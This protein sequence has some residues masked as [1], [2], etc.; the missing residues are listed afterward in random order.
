MRYL[1]STPAQK[2]ERTLWLKMKHYGRTEF[3]LAVEVDKMG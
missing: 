2:L 3:Q 1:V